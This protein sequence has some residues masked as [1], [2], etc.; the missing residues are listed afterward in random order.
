[1]AKSIEIQKAA[2]RKQV[3]SAGKPSAAFF[4]VPWLTPEPV[5]PTVAAEPA[6]DPLPEATVTPLIQEAARAND[7]K[8]E[9]IRAVMRQESAFRA[10]AISAKGAMGLMQL[11]PATAEQFAVKDI[12][13]PKENI[14]AGARYLKQLMTRFNGNLRQVLGAYNAGPGSVPESGEVP[15]IPETR[16]YVQ[17]ILDSL[18]PQDAAGP[19]Q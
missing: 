1:M 13:D 14:S 10:C 15:D 7:L 19:M 2:I 3:G 5:L 6:C 17:S 11:M 4:T 12:F 18:G 9:L 8:P 16:A